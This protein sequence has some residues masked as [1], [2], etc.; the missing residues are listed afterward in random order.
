M[1]SNKEGEIDDAVD[2]LEKNGNEVVAK[3]GN[4]TIGALV[5]YIDSNISKYREAKALVISKDPVMTVIELNRR[6][7]INA[8]FCN[9][10][11]DLK[12]IDKRINAVV[13]RDSRLAVEA[14]GFWNNEEEDE[15]KREKVAER[16][17][18]DKREEAEE[19]PGKP[20]KGIKDRIKF[21]LGIE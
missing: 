7:Q 19:E 16:E 13:L 14:A 11:K 6:Q 1:I 9:D 20:P 18:K 4:Y 17:K 10:E 8:I 3:E 15:E 12:F 5:E 21:Y 2:K